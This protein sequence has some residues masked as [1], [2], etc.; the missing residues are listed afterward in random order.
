MSSSAS[1][2][3]FFSLLPETRTPWTEFAFST[4]AQA[5]AVAFLVWVRLLYPT[6][7]SPPEHTF[8]SI[9]LVSTPV[10]VNHEPQPVRLLQKR[11]VVLLAH[12]DSP[13]SAL[14]L[15]A[16]HPKTPVTLDDDPAPMVSMA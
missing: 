16:P 14:R 2:E 6:V 11:S 1:Q 9:Q 3:T 12:L 10:P 8:Q 7:V 5:I 13:A 4:G 15:P